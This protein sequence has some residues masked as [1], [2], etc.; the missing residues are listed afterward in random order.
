MIYHRERCSSRISRLREEI[1]LHISSSDE[2][3]DQK[4][5]RLDHLNGVIRETFRLHPPVP[6]GLQ[7]LTPP[8]GLEISQM[9]IPGN[10]TVWCSQYA[11]ARSWFCM[12]S[13]LATTHQ[14]AHRRESIYK[15]VLIYPRTLVL[16][17]GDGKKTKRF[18]AILDR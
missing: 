1:A 18:C 4:L 3:L 7:R 13:K 8:E 15:L 17:S 9:H 10:V 11:I 12:F 14:I 16:P 5:Q 6:T 2:V